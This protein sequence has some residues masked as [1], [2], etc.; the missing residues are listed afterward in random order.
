MHPTPHKNPPYRLRA[1]TGLSH[2]LAA[3]CGDHD[4]RQLESA[5]YSLTISD[6]AG[7]E[8]SGETGQSIRLK[9]DT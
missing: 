1:I 6:L 7:A 4:H 5:F 2:G 9:L 3:M 8:Y